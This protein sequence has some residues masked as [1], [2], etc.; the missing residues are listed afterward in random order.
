LDAKGLL[1][2]W[3]EGLLA[4]SVL[5]GKTKGYRSHPQLVRFREQ[6]DPGA[7]INAYL[8]AV[9]AEARARNYRFDHQKLSPI[10]GHPLIPVTVSQLQYE[11]E[12]LLNKLELRDPG[13]C[14]RLRIVT[15]PEPHPMMRKA[16][17]PVAPWEVIK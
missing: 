1:A 5:Q 9:L 6:A 17:G 3:R 16:P 14:R 13:R 15:D 7:A 11:W 2:L 8:H 10:A 12:H 4:K